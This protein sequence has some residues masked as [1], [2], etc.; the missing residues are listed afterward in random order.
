MSPGVSGGPWQSLRPSRARAGSTC[1]RRTA[2]ASPTS[3]RTPP[4]LRDG[5][6]SHVLFPR[7]GT[8]EG[9]GSSTM[10]TQPM[11]TDAFIEI[12]PSGALSRREPLEHSP[13]SASFGPATQHPLSVVSSKP[14]LG[15]LHLPA[16][17]NKFPEGPATHDGKKSFTWQSRA[18][19]QTSP[20]GACPIREPLIRNPAGTSTRRY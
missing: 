4:R 14:S 2:E 20:R 18:V 15:R 11:T 16:S 17:A 8:T 13:R 12:S 1:H 19:D 7:L 5:W 10:I 9:H 6:L 3:T